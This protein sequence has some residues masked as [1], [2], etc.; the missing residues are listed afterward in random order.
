MIYGTHTTPNNI[1][2][3]IKFK[4]AYHYLN[5]TSSNSLLD[6]T[7]VIDIFVPKS[8]GYICVPLK[9]NDKYY[10]YNVLLKPVV[11][12]TDVHQYISI[13]HNI[14]KMYYQ[15]FPSPHRL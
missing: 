3:L 4:N 15:R 13:S 12:S 14:I 5:C 10:A 6:S 9:V 2:K 7:T 8:E 1:Q 11:Y